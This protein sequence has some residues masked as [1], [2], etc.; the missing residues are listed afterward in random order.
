MI[1]WNLIPTYELTITDKANQTGAA[2]NISC[3]IQSPAIATKHTAAF[4][5]TVKATF[6]FQT[7]VKIWTDINETLYHEIDPLGIITCLIKKD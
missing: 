6:L 7:S 1:W 2:G 4:I 3:Y 5:N